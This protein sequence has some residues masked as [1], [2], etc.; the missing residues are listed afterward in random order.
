MSDRPRTPLQTACLASMTPRASLGRRRSG[1]AGLLLLLASAATSVMAQ[2]GSGAP[3]GLTI[4]RSLSVSETLTDARQRSDGTT[5]GDAI[6]TVT[7]AIR[8]V[9][10][11]GQ[12]RGSLDYSLSANLHARDTAANNLQHNLSAA[13]T[14]EILAEHL[15]VDLR[16]SVA[17]QSASA[18]ALQ[19]PDS[20]LAGRSQTHVRSYSIAPL[21]RG[22]PGGVVDMS[23]RLTLAGT[24]SG[25]SSISNSTS[26]AAALHLGS[27]SAGTR[28]GWAL[29]AT[30]QV[31]D[32]DRGRGSEDD[33]LVAGLSMRPLPDLQLGV[34][35]G[36]EN[37]DIASPTKKRTDTW[38][39]G[40]AWTPSERTLVALDADRRS[41]GHSHAFNLQ[42]RLRRTVLRFSDR[43]DV[44]SGVD[45]GTTL[46]PAFDLFFAMFAAQEPDPVKREQL[47]NAFLRNNN[48]PADTLIRAGLL[49]A[50]TALQR[51]QE[52]SLAWQGLRTGLV[53]SGFRTDSR[54][55]ADL[56]GVPDD[57]ATGEL[58]QRGFAV[59]VSH[60]LTP[61]SAVGLAFNSSRSRTV[62]TDAHSD[63]DSL[64]LNWGERLSNRTS[65]SLS[66]RHSESATGTERLNENAVTA[67]LYMLF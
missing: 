6:T 47:V 15:T 39:A 52:L 45:A 11:G 43:Q 67:N 29:D 50:S 61:T 10:R 58:R 14:A 32:F 1:A 62:Q 4:S 42:H 35:V 37:S 36:I 49:T 41:F 17:R 26:K 31:I 55:A 24:D 25:S 7:P 12:I 19:T 65:V 5:S 38:G 27:P 2:D 40:F 33:R 63:I 30:R 28:L 20:N 66:L 54:R 13:A 59:S 21:L 51:R 23:A 8:V 57:L 56:V 60:A 64:S 22:T 16:G 53:L 34:R 48:L 18:L 3:R 44:S 9:S 46:I